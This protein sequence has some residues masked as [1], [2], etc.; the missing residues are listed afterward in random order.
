M[1]L[2]I[3]LAFIT[4]TPALAQVPLSIQPMRPAE[5][6]LQPAAQPARADNG[7]AQPAPI[8]S[9]AAQT[10]MGQLAAITAPS[11]DQELVRME[12]AWSK[13]LVAGDKAALGKIIAPDWRMQNERGT[14]TDRDT[15][16]KN[17][18]DNKFSAMTNRDVHVRFVGDDLAIVQGLDTETSTHKGKNTS[19][20]YSWTDI[21]Q[22]R[23]GQWM[24]IASQ[25]TPV[26]PEK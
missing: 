6:M 20:T 14:A 4:A 13:A 5:E 19:G 17:L 2:A 12:E 3:L 16:F 26:T 18:G 25:N 1:K 8:D 23:N 7:T 24:A 10:P 21:F 9:D 15:Y 11:G 22:K